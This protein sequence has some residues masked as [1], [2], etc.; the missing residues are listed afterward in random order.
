MD[1]A[2]A[3]NVS[4][5]HSMCQSGCV[6]GWPRLFWHPGGRAGV[7]GCWCD[8]TGTVAAPRWGGGNLTSEPLCKMSQGWLLGMAHCAG[9]A[10]CRLPDDASTKALP[11]Q[12]VGH[13]L[14]GWAQ[15][16]T[17]VSLPHL[18]AHSLLHSASLSATPLRREQAAARLVRSA[19]VRKVHTRWSTSCG[20]EVTRRSL[21]GGGRGSSVG[22]EGSGLR[23]G[24]GWDVDEGCTWLERGRRIRRRR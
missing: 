7:H 4:L 14:A 8:S 13:V 3:D 12:E 6:H 22:R 24:G 1:W 2:A 10:F 21:P 16:L 20:R 9:G 11:I 18:P 15:L 5:Q 19:A 23:E 17:W